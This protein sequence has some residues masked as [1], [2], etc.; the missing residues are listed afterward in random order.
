ML[1]IEKSTDFKDDYI[2]LKENKAL[3]K[4]FFV[5]ILYL[6]AFGDYVK[7]CLQDKL[8]VT[9][10]TFSSLMTNLPHF[11]IR[12]HKSYCININKLSRISGNQIHIKTF[13]IPIG[14][15]YKQSLLNALNL[16]T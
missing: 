3:H 13:K 5:D 7:V 6:E 8:I 9:H 16:D 2:V 11:F 14:Q 1:H 4:V 12:I 10:S 15:T